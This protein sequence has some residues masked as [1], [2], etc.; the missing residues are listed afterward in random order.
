M[1]RATRWPARRDERAG[2]ARVTDREDGI[3]LLAGDASLTVDVERGGRLRSL[4]IAGEE[5]LVQ[6]DDPT[7]RSIQWGSFPMAPW[8]GRLRDGILD[9][10]GE[11]HQ[12]RRTLGRHAI[13]GVVFDRPWVVERATATEVELSCALGPAGWPT[14]WRRPA[15]DPAAARRCPAR[16]GDRGRAVDAR[17]LRLAP[18]VPAPPGRTP[19]CA[20]T[21][22]RSWSRAPDPDRRS[23]A[24]RG[25]TDLR[26]GPA[27]AGRRLDHAYV[28][29]RSPA[30]VAWPDLELTIEFAPPASASWSTRRRA[31]CAWSRRRPGRTPCRPTCDQRRGPASRSWRPV[32]ASASRP[33][34]GGGGSRRADPAADARSVSDADDP[35]TARA[36]PAATRRVRPRARRGDLGHA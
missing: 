31:G 21:P 16:S 30:V 7:D 35:A 9:W 10:D 33:G 4:Q 26:R 25:M 22:P 13:H 29:A 8:A 17:R 20:L 27:I 11:R 24:V 6:P 32:R 23:D 14:G 15:A 36:S 12:L 2:N 28:G 3:D 1:V 5:L 18:V 19:G 34:S